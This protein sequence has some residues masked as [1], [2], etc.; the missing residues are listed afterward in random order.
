MILTLADDLSGAAE[1]AELA[2]SKGLRAQV[3]TEIPEKASVDFLAI[4]TQTRTVSPETAA[5]TTKDIIEQS[6]R[7]NPSWF[8]KKTDSALRG[9]IFSETEAMATLARGFGV[10]A[11]RIHLDPMGLDTRA[12]A[13]NSATLAAELGWSR[14]SAVSH[15]YH[16]P[17]LRQ[18]FL[19]AGLP[20]RGVA[21]VESR[22]LARRARFVTREVAA[23]WV[24][25]LRGFRPA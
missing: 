13:R 24:Y 23:W 8:F 6:K 4:D 5:A 21:A 14:I 1:L 3:S 25:W 22:R 19:D 11:S 15:A 17:R 10:E 7:L 9:N 20:A 12:T 16:V 2:A 18:A